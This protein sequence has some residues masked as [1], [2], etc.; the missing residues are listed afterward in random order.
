MNDMGATVSPAPHSIVLHVGGLHYATE[1]AVVEQVLAHRPG[2]IAVDANP[3]A[4]TATV[5]FDPAA[6]SVEELRG[7]VEECGW[8][9]AIPRVRRIERWRRTGSV[10]TGCQRAG[11]A[12]S[13][14]RVRGLHGY[15]IDREQVEFN[16]AD[17]LV[18]PRP[19]ERSE[20]GTAATPSRRASGTRRRYRVPRVSS[21]CRPRCALSVPPSVA[22]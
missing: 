9:H 2:V 18:M 10:P 22:F 4:Q 3:V 20:P 16:P 14:A 6:T 21:A 7:W 12:R 15:A 1:K 8:P 5:G 19:D 17:A 11:S 13:L